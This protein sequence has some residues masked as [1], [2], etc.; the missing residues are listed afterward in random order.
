MAIVDSIH[1]RH[2]LPRDGAHRLAGAW[3]APSHIREHAEDA[4][5]QHILAEIGP[6]AT[7]L[8]GASVSFMN[9]T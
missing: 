4:I 9:L 1:T 3:E 5:F 7:L 8:A 2:R 6:K